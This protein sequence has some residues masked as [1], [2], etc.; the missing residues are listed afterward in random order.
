MGTVWSSFFLL[1]VKSNSLTQNRHRAVDTYHIRIKGPLF[2]TKNLVLLS[3]ESL[4]QNQEASRNLSG[5]I[6]F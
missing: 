5:F 6:I 4:K 2:S 3:S 1:L